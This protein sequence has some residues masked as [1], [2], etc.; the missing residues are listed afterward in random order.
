VPHSLVTFHV[1]Y[2][3]RPLQMLVQQLASAFGREAGAS[4]VPQLQGGALQLDFE[5][6]GHGGFEAAL[7]DIDHMCEEL[8]RRASP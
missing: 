3:A 6:G 2:P 5:G 8:D 7:L 4:A 1:P